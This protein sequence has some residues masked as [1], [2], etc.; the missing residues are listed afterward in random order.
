MTHGNRT[1]QGITEI[2]KPSSTSPGIEAS[3]SA[4]STTTR[5]RRARSLTPFRRRSGECRLEE[6]TDASLGIRVGGNTLLR[7]EDG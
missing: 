3:R 7:K 2:T 1:K 5:R 4:W 6:V